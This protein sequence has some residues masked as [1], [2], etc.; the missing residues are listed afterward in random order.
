MWEY[1]IAGIFLLLIAW[2]IF[3]AVLWIIDFIVQLVSDITS[4]VVENSVMFIF[5]LILIAGIYIFVL[6]VRNDEERKRQKS[7]ERRKLSIEKKLRESARI[8]K[9]R[10]ELVAKRKAEVRIAEQRRIELE[11]QT[12]D[13]IEECRRHDMNKSFI[14]DLQPVIKSIS[15]IPTFR[16]IL[17]DI[18]TPIGKPKASSGYDGGKRWIMN[19]ITGLQSSSAAKKDI[20]SMMKKVVR[21]I[22]NEFP[23][24]YE[25]ASDAEQFSRLV[26]LWR[27]Y[28]EMDRIVIER[29]FNGENDAYVLADM[30]LLQS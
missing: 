4:Y 12:T 8:E 9:E 14:E 22:E 11:K 6:K 27:E 19:E 13:L 25:R 30:G 26:N 7:E 17:L 2:L 24:L 20:K 10:L 5:L 3:L 16:Q 18:W 1:I 29:I 21:P 15:T 23:L 28:G